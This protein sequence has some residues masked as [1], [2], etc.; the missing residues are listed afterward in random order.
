MDHNRLRGMILGLVCLFLTACATKTQEAQVRLPLPKTV[1]ESSFPAKKLFEISESYLEYHYG[2][3]VRVRD[4]ERGL[5]VSDWSRENPTERHQI[6]LRVSPN[7]KG[8]I[9]S[10]HIKTE[11]FTPEGWKDLPTRGEREGIFLSDL[12]SY[13]AQKPSTPTLR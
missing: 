1:L 10:A 12:Q 5:I 13:L 7:E 6:T 3:S 4:L 11:A 8:S 2:Y 9:L